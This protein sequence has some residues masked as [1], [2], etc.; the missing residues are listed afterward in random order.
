[1][2]PRRCTI[3]G[4]PSV[5]G[6]Q[7]HRGVTFHTF[8]L[9]PI[10]RQFWLT[11]CNLPDTKNI[12]KSILVCSRHFRR[13][14]FQP[15]KN[16]KYLLKQG[17][18]PTIFPW[19]TLPY[20]E[21]TPHSVIE[22][23]E[24]MVIADD[25]PAE[26]LPLVNQQLVDEIVKIKSEMKATIGVK[27]PGKRSA[28]VDEPGTSEPKKKAIRVSL[29]SK[30]LSN[31]PIA[32]ASFDP[33][34]KFSPGARIEAQDFNGAWH[35]AKVV[36]V[37]GDEKEVLINF[38][39]NSK[40]KAPATAT[41]WIPM[42]SS[43]L[44]QVVKKPIASYVPGEKCLAR[45]TDSRKFPATIQKVL[46]N[47]TYE[48][49]FDDGFVKVVR[50]GHISKVKV[51]EP[52]TPKSDKSGRKSNPHLPI[53]KFDLAK[54]NLLPVPKDGEWCCNWVNEIP[55][56]AEGYLDGPDGHKRPTVL[57]EDWRLP[58]GWT[59]HLYQRSSVSGKWDVVLVG[60]T[61][62]RFRSK[63][64][65]KVYLEEK[66]EVY[67]PDIY[68]FSIHKRRAKDIGLFVFTD[69]YK[70]ELKNK[71][72][73]AA[74]TAATAASSITPLL[75]NTSDDAFQGFS[76]KESSFLS[77]TLPSTPLSS[78]GS[79]NASAIPSTPQSIPL[80]QPHPPPPPLPPT[81]PGYVYVGALKVQLIDNLFHCP[82]ATCNKNFRKENH[83]QIHVKHYHLDLAKLLGVCPNMSDLAYQRTV[84]MPIDEAV[85]KNQIPN[86]QF[87]EKVYQSDL[88]SK[89]QRKSM[90]PST[91]VKAEPRSPNFSEKAANISAHSDE[92]DKPVAEPIAQSQE[93]ANILHQSLSNEKNVEQI[94]HAQECIGSPKKPEAMPLDADVAI[95]KKSETPTARTKATKR[96]PIKPLNRQKARRN[97]KK[98]FMKSLQEAKA[99][100]V[101]DFGDANEGRVPLSSVSE[102]SPTKSSRLKF[103]QPVDI[104]S[105]KTIAHDRQHVPEMN[106]P[107]PKYINENGEVIK[108]VR[109]RQEEIIN[110][111][112]SYVE[113]DGLMIQCELC[114]CWQHGICNGIEKESQVPEKYICYI[115]RN[116]QRGRESM[117]YAHDQDWLLAGKLPVA[118]YHPANSKHTERFD[119][120]KQ[121]HTLTGNLIELK[122]FMHSL[123][124][125]INIA[126]NKD[127]PKMYLWSKKWEKCPTTAELTGIE[128]LAQSDKSKFVTNEALNE[129]FS[130]TE[131]KKDAVKEEELNTPM[132]VA[133]DTSDPNEDKTATVPVKEEEAAL[134]EEKPNVFGD[135]KMIVDQSILAGLLN[136]SGG[137]NVEQTQE[138]VAVKIPQPEAAINPSE[139]QLLLLD[140]IQKQQNLVMG[141]LQTI[142]AQ[143]IALECRDDK[144][145]IMEQPESCSKTKQIISL[146]LNDLQK[147]RKIAAINSMENKLEI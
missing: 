42:N 136:S 126:E 99:S 7:Q 117:K 141:R 105:S 86:S 120:L 71:Q 2:A 58:A 10:A 129:L 142:E 41:E 119:M 102:L 121:S 138:T 147:M 36:E 134:T 43:R 75:L 62:K 48:V 95:V 114:L 140:H 74:S 100:I 35:T 111:L 60:P 15:L 66:G 56:G 4:C 3:K 21:P 143:I 18:V 112:C 106:A 76:S 122:R 81:D 90:S 32:T 85:P 84:G 116:P 78:I 1:M 44:R 145:D 27:S 47:N 93:I 89:L 130:N 139:C 91:Q 70:E 107:H 127:H 25:K 98:A 12:T 92:V 57:V 125:K 131:V 146:L 59:K 5:S 39:K 123:N 109:M 26:P 46:E 6:R 133:A 29:D 65:V 72:L 24:P 31:E 9:N 20:V 77:S 63:N 82:E 79:L 88:S 55:I 128:M 11:N 96:R 101:K 135:D 68:D 30:K 49:L 37:D 23:G 61:K 53:P 73:L 19:G 94:I 110:C 38:E 108:I 13:A 83:L 8:P 103:L 51:P 16:N 80:L 113:E 104:G 69:E 33:F 115:C 67:N 45:W 14:D 137:V 52:K 54:L 64:D 124:V 17:A 28:S 34:S 132:E 118:N 40:S 144:M 97:I 50:A 87:F 22:S